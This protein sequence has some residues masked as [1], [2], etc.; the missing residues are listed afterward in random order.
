MVKVIDHQQTG[1]RKFIIG[2]GR[3]KDKPLV[4]EKPETKFDIRT[5]TYLQSKP[6]LNLNTTTVIE[7]RI[8]KKNEDINRL[9]RQQPRYFH[10]SY[11]KGPEGKFLNCIQKSKSYII[12]FNTDEKNKK[13]IFEHLN[14]ITKMIESIKLK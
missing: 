5:N 14:N 13:N 12:H 3:K 4:E 11:K 8:I 9:E 10:K 6:V 1:K 2:P 7:R